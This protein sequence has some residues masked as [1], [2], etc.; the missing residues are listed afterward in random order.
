M[1]ELVNDI[2]N[3]LRKVCDHPQS[4]TEEVTVTNQLITNS[5]L[6]QDYVKAHEEELLETG[7]PA[8][9]IAAQFI[10]TFLKPRPGLVTIHVCMVP[11]PSALAV[12]ESSTI[13]LSSI[14]PYQMNN[15]LPLKKIPFQPGSIPWS[16]EELQV[17]GSTSDQVNITISANF[18]EQDHVPHQYPSLLI[19]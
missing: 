18:R 16:I 12:T 8:W 9:Y 6:I 3:C 7:T 4:N 1:S 2:L 10:S 14:F 11:N 17:N 15:N 13:D 19:H 5:T